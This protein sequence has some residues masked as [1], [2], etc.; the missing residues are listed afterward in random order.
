MLWIAISIAVVVFGCLGAFMLGPTIKTVFA[1]DF[2]P[3][4]KDEASVRNALMNRMPDAG[5]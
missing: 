2:E 1:P 4:P 3:A 5:Q